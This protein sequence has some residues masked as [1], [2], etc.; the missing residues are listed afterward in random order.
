MHINHTQVHRVAV[1][2]CIVCYA[3]ISTLDEFIANTSS[4]FML[5][6]VSAL[7]R[8]PFSSLKL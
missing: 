7:Y 8:S 1:I 2:G 3:V 5:R 6:V 4:P